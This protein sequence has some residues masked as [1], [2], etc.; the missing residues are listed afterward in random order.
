MRQ[1]LSHVERATA[2]LRDLVQGIMPAAL[3]R[4]GLRQGVE[5]LLDHVDLPVELDLPDVRLPPAIETTAYF[6]VAEALTNAVK[7][8]GAS[9]AAVTARLADGGL[10]LDFRDDGC[11]GADPGRGSGLLGLVDRVAAGG[12]T[13]EVTSR[14]GAGTVLAMWLPIGVGAEAREPVAAGR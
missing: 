3:L 5:S 9:R 1:A 14:L 2:E 7:H 12:G 11:G 6:L 13:L 10:E 8:S 4:G